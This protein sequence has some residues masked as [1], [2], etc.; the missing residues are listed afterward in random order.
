[1]LGG[2]RSYQIPEVINEQSYDKSVDLYL[3]GLLAYELLTGH[4]AYPPDLPDLEGK[5]LRQDY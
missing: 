2:G 5:I 4:P 1:M 3:F